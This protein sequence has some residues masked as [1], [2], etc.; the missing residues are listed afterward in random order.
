MN[1]PSY[2]SS[3]ICIILSILGLHFYPEDEGSMLPLKMAV[4]IYHKTKPHI[5]EYS[6]VYT[7]FVNKRNMLLK[8]SIFL[9]FVLKQEWS[10]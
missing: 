7:S 10:Q 1:S 3:S 5:P 9:P 6:T 8:T 2:P 4:S